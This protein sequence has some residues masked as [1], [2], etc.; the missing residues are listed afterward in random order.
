MQMAFILLN[1]HIQETGAVR[2]IIV[3]IMT[4]GNNKLD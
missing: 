1:N 2:E 4:G 3:M